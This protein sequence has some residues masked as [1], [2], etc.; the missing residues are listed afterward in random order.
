M[1]ERPHRAA[2]RRTPR[3]LDEPTA[4]AEAMTLCRRARRRTSEPFVVDADTH[5]QTLAVLAHPGRAAGHRAGG[6]RPVRRRP[7]RR[8]TSSG[9]LLVRTPAPR[10]RSATTPA[11]VAQAHER[12]AL[13]VV[14]ADL[15]ALT[16]LRP[17]G[18]SGAD[19]V[20]GSAQR[21][22]VP[23]GLRRPARR[24]HGG[25]RRPG[26]H[27][28]RPA[29]RASASTP[30]APPA[31]RLA[32]QTREQH[33]RREK[34]TSNI[35][36][37]QVL[38]AVVAVDVRRLPRAGGAARASPARTHR[39]R[40]ACW[41][42][43]CAAGGVESCTR[44]FFDTVRARCPGARPRSSARG[45]A[46]R[47]C[48]LRLRRRRHRR[49]SAPT[50][51][52]LA[53]HV[54][55]VWAAFG[56]GR[57]AASTDL[58]ALDAATPDALPRGAAA[59]VATYLTH[60]VFHAHRSETAMLRYLRRLADTRLRARPRD[61]P[62]GLVHHEA[63]RH[64]R[65]GADHLA[66]VRRHP[67]VRAR[68]DQAAG[69][70]R[71]DPHAGGA[72]WPRSPA[73]TRSRVQ[74][75]AGLARA[76]SPGCSR[77]APTTAS[78][79]EARPR[80]VPHPVQRPRH[81]RRQRRHGRACAWSS[82]RATTTATSTS[83]TCAPRSTSTRERLA[84]LMITYPSTHG[85]FEDDGRRHLRAGARRRR[86]GVRRR[87]QPQR[88]GRARQAGPVRRRRLAPEPAQDL[89]HPA[90]RRRARGRARWPCARTWRRTCR[91]TRCARGGPL[92]RGTPTAAS[93]RSAARRGAAPA[94]CRSRGPT[95][96]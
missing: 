80:R 84:A 62:A 38:L 20:V 54:R 15:L 40:R 42:R 37:A 1:V 3:L 25:A 72:G 39:L 34:A 14:A 29:G 73:T 91:P 36:T 6:R 49:R 77:S 76:S 75:N 7:A 23:L 21:F 10:A 24:L 48:N 90:R 83:T 68:C 69:Y 58:H 35:C 46:A 59:R 87:R 32:L 5:P 9:V 67:P 71:A 94:S 19:V 4:A 12:G 81:Q 88:A 51:P 61:D 50:R 78:R 16:L 82:W 70:R 85:V 89:L 95:S 30:T 13:V 8:A 92:G 41:P 56:G 47:A 60:P 55:G 2:G 28:A 53:D 44:S 17:P 79:G 26:A 45:R 65:D 22:G 57:G 74:P 66:G 27:A 64:H 63:Q 52:P 93:A 96:G 31:Y 43:A 11:L 33:I 18:E 86:P